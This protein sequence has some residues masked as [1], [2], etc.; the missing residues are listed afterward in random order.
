MKKI[1]TL[2][3]L[4][5]LVTTSFFAQSNYIPFKTDSVVWSDWVRDPNGISYILDHYR[6]VGDTIINNTNYTILTKIRSTQN[7][8]APT[9][10][11]ED[12]I[13]FYRNDSINKKVYFLP[14]DS[15]NEKLF[16]DFD[17]AVGDTLPDTYFYEKYFLNPFIIDSIGDTTLADSVLR[18][19]YYYSENA[20]PNP[21]R[22]LV[23][24][25]GTLAGFIS[26]F[27]GGYGLGAN[28][29]LV[30][31][32][33]AGNIIYH[34]SSGLGCPALPVLPVSL[35]EVEIENLSLT[36]YP[37]PSKG[38]FTLRFAEEIE[39]S[40]QLQITNL[41]GQTVNFEISENSSNQ[42]K[43]RLN[44]PPGVYLLRLG[45]VSKKIIVW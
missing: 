18:K 41:N 38:E 12:T 31:Y 9:F 42:L 36:I 20:I 25:I 30:C 28:S 16:Y 19:M 15:T 6:S 24:G 14:I 1:I 34:S 23:E 11:N 10:G 39:K 3:S 26:S 13:G 17:L 37:N 27:R 29:S 35:D 5:T 21:D 32:R 4:I 40:E 22:I 44:V 7:S 33:V 43:V 45:S 8:P 2:L